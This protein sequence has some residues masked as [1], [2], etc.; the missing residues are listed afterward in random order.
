MVSLNG[1]LTRLSTTANH[2]NTSQ[3]IESV[4][5]AQVRLRLQL[6]ARVCLAHFRLHRH[7]DTQWRCREPWLRSHA[8]NEVCL[9]SAKKPNR[10]R[11]RVLVFDCRRNCFHPTPLSTVYHLGTFATRLLHQLFACWASSSAQLS[12]VCGKSAG[13][14]A[15]RYL[16]RS[17]L[18]ELWEKTMGGIKSTSS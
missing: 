7:W 1:D 2:C 4:E 6:F 11:N 3:P 8:A 14:T 12:V 10:Y 18:T 15:P 16:S 17:H 5:W 13:T 9:I